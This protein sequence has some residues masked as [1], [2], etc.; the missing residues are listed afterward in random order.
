MQII[1]SICQNASPNERPDL[2]AVRSWLITQAG[3]C[4]ERIRLCQITA[5]EEQTAT[6]RPEQAEDAMKTGKRKRGPA[7]E[8]LDTVNESDGSSP[9]SNGTAA[10]GTATNGTA[11][12]GTLSWL[13]IAHLRC[14][15][16]PES[17]QTLLL[18][19]QGNDA[20]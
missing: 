7:I 6:L 5:L 1:S 18:L 10:N 17:S 9:T 8:P 19:V 16:P 20:F 12:N 2:A 13:N 4:T 3:S 15:M 11:T 14:T